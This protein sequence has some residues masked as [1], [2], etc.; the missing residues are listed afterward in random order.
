[1][2]WKSN[3]GNDDATV[4]SFTFAV[5]VLLF[6]CRRGLIYMCDSMKLSLGSYNSSNLCLD[7]RCDF[8]YDPRTQTCDRSIRLFFIK[9]SPIVF[10]SLGS[11]NVMLCRVS[12]DKMR[13]I[14]LFHRD[15]CLLRHTIHE[16]VEHRS[17]KHTHK[18]S[19]RQ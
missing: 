18:Y 8:N 2:L 17:D 11:F 16:P 4:L 3:E 15:I 6:F 9:H 5:F 1:M 14:L 12:S 10:Y 13:Y 19:R 7:D